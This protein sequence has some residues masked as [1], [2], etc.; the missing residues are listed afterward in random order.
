MA[1]KEWYRVTKEMELIGTLHKI[2]H[3]IIEAYCSYYG[4]WMECLREFT[5]TGKIAKTKEGNII[6]HPYVSMANKFFQLM[7]KAGVE[8]GISPSQ[9]SRMHVESPDKK[10]GTVL[11]FA[12]SKK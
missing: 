11:D 1:R 9:R 12:R 4:E 3:A 2:D 7:L 5:K 6:Q 8:L 10:E